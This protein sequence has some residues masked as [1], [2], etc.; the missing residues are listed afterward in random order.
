MLRLRALA[1]VQVSIY[2][3]L[4]L[5]T[6][7]TYQPTMSS[8]FV[9]VSIFFTLF[10][11]LINVTTVVANVNISASD[12]RVVWIG[13]HSVEVD[14]SVIADWSGVE[15]RVQV[16]NG[17]QLLRVY[18][19]AGN[20]GGQRYA[21]WVSST[22]TGYIPTRVSSFW[23]GG[24]TTSVDI[25]LGYSLQYDCTVS[26]QRTVEPVFADI[27]SGAQTRF[28]AFESDVGFSD[29]PPPRSSRR[30]EF[31]GD[32]ITA[33]LGNLGSFNAGCWASPFTQDFSFGY[34][35][36]ICK[37]F[38]AECSTLAWSGISLVERSTGPQ[39]AACPTG[40][41]VLPDF[42][43]YSV[44]TMIPTRPWNFSS[45]IPQIVHINLGTN[46]QKGNFSNA[47]FSQLFIDSYVTFIKQIAVSYGAM[48]PSEAPYFFIA[49]GPM[50]S[51][52]QSQVQT[53]ANLLNPLGYNITVI[54]YSIPDY[55]IDPG[56]EWHPNVADHV[57]MAEIAS[58]AI[59][60]VTGW[61]K[62]GPPPPEITETKG[63][64]IV[65]AVSKISIPPEALARRANRKEN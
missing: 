52:Y 64:T 30:I 37:A 23:T 36:E 54:D 61:K 32:S 13:R 35:T 9:R 46:D 28:L 53:V 55:N 44:P 58:S 7:I 5:S 12:P 18:L 38:N 6:L 11:Y 25:L 20:P 34:A 21:V 51:A 40:Y 42:Y 15:A 16:A 14:G 45:F 62:V 1:E 43:N 39:Y 10:L 50:S 48:T 24:G 65:G 60:N 59:Q 49:Y 8:S 27:Y 31:L 2:L 4:F 19:N 29:I 56:C 26:I 33:C 63:E 57:M 47:T 41:C 3:I 17:S 22:A